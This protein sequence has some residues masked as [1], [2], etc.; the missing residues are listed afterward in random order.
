METL[1]VVS[2]GGFGH[3]VF[4]FDDML[5]M[6]AAE[7]CG[8]A[9]A[10]A[11]EDISFFT[12]HALCHGKRVFNN[13]PQMLAELKPDVAV[14]STRLD[15][16][17]DVAMEAAKAGCHLICEK[18]LALNSEKLLDLYQVV[19][20]TGVKL[21]AMLSMRSEPQFVTAHELYQSGAI[22]AAVMV[23][24][25]KS[26]KWGTRP[27]W[28]SS[29]DMYGGTI[30]WVGIHA[31]DMIN[32][33]TGLEFVSVS[34]MCN[35]FC[36]P[37][38][39]ACDDNCCMLLELSNGGHATVSVDLFRPDVSETHGDDWIRIVGT[40]G[41]IEASGSALT[42]TL[43]KRSKTPETISLPDKPKIFE[44]FLLSLVD[45]RASVLNAKSAFM[46]TE[47]SHCGQESLK[48]RANVSIKNKWD[49]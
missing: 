42:C 19:K 28:F 47:S 2:I 31:L 9:P 45:D 1:K 6:E 48:R 3:S 44:T 37:E 46:L 30:G 17:A 15:C 14:I 4:V 41:I 35:N 7:L 39:E 25:R 26:Y 24:S 36:H 13:Y 38:R 10:F 5:G 43:L 34:A 33:I 23:N 40:D 18:P 12:N 8:L 21:S 11:G 49:I 20:S 27:E 32:Y 29:M 22:G 16:I